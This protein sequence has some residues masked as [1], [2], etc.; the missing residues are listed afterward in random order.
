MNL[1]GVE[2]RLVVWWLCQSWYFKR[3]RLW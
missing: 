1:K 3:F 2:R